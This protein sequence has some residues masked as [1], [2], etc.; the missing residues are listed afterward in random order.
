MPFPVPRSEP[1]YRTRLG[2]P[3]QAGPGGRSS[4]LC[5]SELCLRKSLRRP[6]I[7]LAVSIFQEGLQRHVLL[8]DKS[9]LLDFTAGQQVEHGADRR[10]RRDLD[11]G[12]RLAI[13]IAAVDFVGGGLPPE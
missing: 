10:S 11:R 8:A 12:Q 7:D 1:R 4:S 13:D 6:G 3:V 2:G 9:S 5:P